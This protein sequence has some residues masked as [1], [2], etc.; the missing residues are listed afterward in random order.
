MDFW[1]SSVK[2]NQIPYSESA[3]SGECWG[4]TKMKRSK[5]DREQFHSTIVSTA[6]RRF[7]E[8]GLQGVGVDEIMKEAG[9]TAGGF[10]RHFGSRDDLVVEALED[11]FKQLDVLE[12]E[13][14]DLA[15]WVRAYVSN[16]HCADPGRGCA[17]AALAGDVRHAS[18]ETRAVFTARVK[19]TLTH[20][21][22]R[23]KGRDAQARRARAILLFS[24]A[25][26]GITI[27]R[28]VNDKKLA[29]EVIGTLRE[30]LLE[31]SVEP[32]RRISKPDR[33]AAPRRDFKLG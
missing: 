25:L 9:A 27:A 31:L 18:E 33:P 8:G 28:A 7:R 20:H 3:D 15:S 6:A 30:Q 12:A 2:V 26:G 19:H 16:E 10:Y 5:A 14:D 11:A 24:A 21:S 4:G 13:N 23:I 32:A 17:L 1:F 22:D 29:R